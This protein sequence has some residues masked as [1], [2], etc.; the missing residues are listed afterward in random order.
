MTVFVLR[1]E[2]YRGEPPTA[3]AVFREEVDAHTEVLDFAYKQGFAGMLMT[4]T[5]PS[6]ICERWGMTPRFG[7]ARCADGDHPGPCRSSRTNRCFLDPISP[8]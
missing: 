1:F 6:P 8:K 3:T 7:N 4:S 2:L 5:G